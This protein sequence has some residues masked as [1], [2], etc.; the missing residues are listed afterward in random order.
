MTAYV[1]PPDLPTALEARAAHPEYIVL[2]G[3]TDLM[4]GALDRPTPEGAIDLFG[5]PDLCEIEESD[6]GLRVGAAV[7]YSKLL[8]DPRV[9]DRYPI[10]HN[11]VREIGAMQIQERGTIGGNVATSSPVGDTLPVLLALDATVEVAS[12]SGTRQVPYRDFCTG[13]RQTALHPNELIIA[14]TLPPL[15]PDAST[16]WRKVGTRRAQAIS[17]VMV[18]GHARITDGKLADVR[19]ALGA[20]ADRPIRGT[21]V[22][23]LLEGTAPTAE[24]AAEAAR[25]MRTEISPIDDVRSTAYYR[26]TIA[27]NLT[28]RFVQELGGFRAIV[29]E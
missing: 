16:Y 25:I 22:E 10:L 23:T 27:A 29:S 15:G 8:H 21:A 18:A 14:L 19:W 28:A 2:A 12:R 26:S 11:C 20:V 5:L 3:G 24:L 1:R 6:G 13:Y 17:K 7:P 9:G 4:V